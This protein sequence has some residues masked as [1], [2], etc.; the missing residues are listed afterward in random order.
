MIT[1]EYSVPNTHFTNFLSQTTSF[2]FFI[3]SQLTFFPTYLF[4][5]VPN[6]LSHFCFVSNHTPTPPIQ[7]RKIVS[8]AEL[9]KGEENGEK[10]VGLEGVEEEDE[11]WAEENE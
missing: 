6:L 8:L 5:S 4:L 2:M 1:F 11:G 7:V 10:A 3:R 9:V